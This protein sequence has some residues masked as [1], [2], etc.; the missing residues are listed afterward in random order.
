MCRQMRLVY[1]AVI[2]GTDIV[3]F[4]V[5]YSSMFYWLLSVPQNLLHSPL[6]PKVQRGNSFMSKIVPTDGCLLYFVLSD[7]GLF[8]KVSVCMFFDCQCICL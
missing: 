6:L 3:A 5:V 7:T 2:F 1:L 8:C 4:P